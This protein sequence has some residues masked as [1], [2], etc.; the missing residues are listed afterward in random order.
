MGDE[1]SSVER[2]GAVWG[3]LIYPRKSI[4]GWETNI[5]CTY[6]ESPLLME[7]PKKVKI[8]F[9]VFCTTCSNGTMEILV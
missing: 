8:K 1:R 7:I 3:G 2:M 4:Q 9:K 5:V 6:L